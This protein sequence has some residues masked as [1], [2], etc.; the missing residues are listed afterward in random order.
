M[1]FDPCYYDALDET[2]ADNQKVSI[3][4]N[5]TNGILFVET[6]HSTSLQTQ[7]YHITVSNLL[8][9]TLQ[10]TTANGDTTLDLSHYE[11]GMYLIRIKTQ[12]EVTVFKV[13]VRQ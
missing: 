8:G 10:E 6:Q 12:S 1:T 2:S 9:Q 3:Y 4:P 13:D 7:T 11:P 5:P